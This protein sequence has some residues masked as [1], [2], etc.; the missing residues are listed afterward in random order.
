MDNLSTQEQSRI[1]QDTGQSTPHYIEYNLADYCSEKTWSDYP[2]RHR[3][4]LEKAV[5]IRQPSIVDFHFNDTHRQHLGGGVG[6]RPSPFGPQFSLIESP[7]TTTTLVPYCL[8]SFYT[9][10]GYRIYAEGFATGVENGG[11]N[12]FTETLHFKGHS[13]SE[14]IG[15]GLLETTTQKD[16]LSLIFEQLNTRRFSFHLVIT[17]F[18]DSMT[19]HITFDHCDSSREYKCRNERCIAKYLT[20]DHHNNC[21]DYSDEGDHCLSKVPKEPFPTQLPPPQEPYDFDGQPSPEVPTFDIN[22]NRIDFPIHHRPPDSDIPEYV[23]VPLPTDHP[24]YVRHNVSTKR[25]FQYDTMNGIDETGTIGAGGFLED[26]F[27]FSSSSKVSSVVYVVRYLLVVLVII[28]L[29]TLVNFLIWCLITK[30]DQSFMAPAASP[31]PTLRPQQP[32]TSTMSVISD[33]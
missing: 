32:A 3:I 25:P 7:S 28:I 1:P 21:G 13:Q 11:K 4:R 17:P 24:F 30:R 6:G 31:T 8:L 20:C 10:F 14:T 16:T 23:D 2:G 5:K 33:V 12:W 22:G 18:R 27:T 26:L 19:D 9:D 15:T 29:V